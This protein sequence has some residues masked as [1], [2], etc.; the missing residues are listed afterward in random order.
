VYPGAVEEPDAC[1]MSEAAIQKASALF[2][3]GSP[4]HCGPSSS[5]FL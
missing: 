4:S 2:L 3:T 1:S 5:S